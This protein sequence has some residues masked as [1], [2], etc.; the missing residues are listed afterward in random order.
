MI[1][2]RGVSIDLRSEGWLF[3]DIWDRETMYRINDRLVDINLDFT[4]DHTL[5]YLPQYVE[6]R[7]L[8]LR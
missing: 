3:L 2:V 7:L 4:S 5:L 6:L 8:V 1:Y